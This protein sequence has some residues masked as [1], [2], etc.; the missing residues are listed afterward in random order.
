MLPR[1][2]TGQDF[3]K[4]TGPAVNALFAG[5]ASEEERFPPLRDALDGARKMHYW[6][7]LTAD[8]NDDFDEF[9]GQHKFAQA[10]EAQMQALLVSQSIEVLCGAVFQIAKQAISLVLHDKD[11]YC[12]GRKIGSQHLSAVI[13]H[14][15]NQAMH[16]ERGV[17]DP[18]R[19][20]WTIDCFKMLREDFGAQFEFS[21]TPRNMAWDLWKVI[22]WTSYEAY[23]VDMKEILFHQK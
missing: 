19:D 8:L 2:I 15:R 14:G 9:Y 1:D 18:K 4:H 3:L 21:D 11:R 5:I 10:A 6:D 17:P 7:F 23:E 12:K 13:W 20:K 16:W 22:G